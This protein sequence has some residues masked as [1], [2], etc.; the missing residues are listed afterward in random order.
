MNHGDA[1]RGQL[2]KLYNV[3]RGARQR[4]TTNPRSPHYK[5]YAGRGI[6]FDSCWD[7]YSTFR[8]WAM[9]NGYREGLSIDRVD[10]DLGYSPKNCRWAS[11]K[12]QQRN[13]TKNKLTADTVGILRH[14][15]A[16]GLRYKQL[17]KIFKIHPVYLS[18]VCNGGAW[19]DE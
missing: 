4:C 12:Q 13:T 11:A 16:R 1:K 14:L 5:M 17:A 19:A 8:D 6:S 18:K 15:R 3:W 9:A 2:S 7:E 10:N